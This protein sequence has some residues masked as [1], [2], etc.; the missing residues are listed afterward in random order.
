MQRLPEKAIEQA[1]QATDLDK[2]LSS[3]FWLMGYC[4]KDQAAASAW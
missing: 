1:Q 3:A 2:N 4:Y